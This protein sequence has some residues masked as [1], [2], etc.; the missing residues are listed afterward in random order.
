MTNNNLLP[1]NL[2][3]DGIQSVAVHNGIARVLFMRLDVDGKPLPAVEL[4]IPM[5]QMK[6][7]SQALGK[8]K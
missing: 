3:V 8:V 4:N 1:L 6:A 7:I 2:V 5:N